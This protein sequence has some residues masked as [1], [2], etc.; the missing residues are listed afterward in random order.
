MEN[1]EEIIERIKNGEKEL[2]SVVLENHKK[3]IY[4][5]ISTKSLNKGDFM[6]DAES[7]YQ[8]GCIALYNAIFTYEKDRGMSFSSYAYMVIRGKIS[9]YIRD[10]GKL[11]DEEYYS[12]DSH[13]NIDYYVSMASMCVSEDPVAYHREQEFEEK[14]N[15]FVNSLS[16]EDRQIFEGRR[17]ELSYKQIAE[18]LKISSKRVDN[19]LTVLRK[20]L[21]QYLNN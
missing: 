15:K 1:C 3:M 9:T 12:I 7:L 8:E 13:E 6:I 19:R 16:Q 18:R 17:E 10:H 11:Y 2:Y 20:K 4:K 5:I 21:R 14:L